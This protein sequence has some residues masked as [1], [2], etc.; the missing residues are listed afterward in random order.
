MPRN[1]RTAAHSIA[2]AAAA[3]EAGRF[4]CGLQLN[5]CVWT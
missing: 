5:T 3:A 2:A 4:R 1:R